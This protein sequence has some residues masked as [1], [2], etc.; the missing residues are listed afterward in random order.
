M[1]IRK[2]KLSFDKLLISFVVV[3]EIFLLICD[4]ERCFNEWMRIIY[5]SLLSMNE[6]RTFVS[7]DIQFNM[8]L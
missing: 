2:K 8:K 7:N 1:W 4:D 5:N 3:E 6:Y